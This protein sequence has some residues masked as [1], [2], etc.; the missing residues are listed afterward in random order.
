MYNCGSY[1]IF[2]QLF[3][4]IVFRTNFS[5][6]YFSYDTFHTNI[7]RTNFSYR[8]FSYNYFSLKSPAPEGFRGL[9]PGPF[10]DSCY[11]EY[12]YE[13]LQKLIVR[14]V[15]FSDKNSIL[16]KISFFFIK[17]QNIFL[18]LFRC[19]RPIINENNT[20]NRSNKVPWEFGSAFFG[21][22]APNYPY[23]KF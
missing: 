9:V 21:F 3:C 19:T 1:G 8:Y 6:G 17:S 18:T 12:L 2:V 4:T 20:R 22:F 7:F 16:T 23:K 14:E 13:K 15:P 5:Y 10:F 11:E